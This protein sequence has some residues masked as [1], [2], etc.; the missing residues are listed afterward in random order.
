MK[1]V[2]KIKFLVEYVVM[3]C[4]NIIM[5]VEYRSILSTSFYQFI[6]MLEHKAKSIT[7]FKKIDPNYTSKAC[8]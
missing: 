5:K 3:L 2:N 6:S 4:Y 7:N 8:S 1:S